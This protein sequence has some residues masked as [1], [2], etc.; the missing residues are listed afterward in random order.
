M[1]LHVQ[2]LAIKSI[3][4]AVGLHIRGLG[5][6]KQM[7]PEIDDE[8]VCVQFA[9]HPSRGYMMFGWPS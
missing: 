4:D 1:I 5:K 9:N 3:P 8:V 2:L 6:K 7:I